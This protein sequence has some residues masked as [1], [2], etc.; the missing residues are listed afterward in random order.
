[1]DK[2]RQEIISQLKLDVSKRFP[3]TTILVRFKFCLTDSRRRLSLIEVLWQKKKYPDKQ[4]LMEKQ[5]IL[6]RIPYQPI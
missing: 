6:L 4:W 5:D 1:V 2:A 3:T